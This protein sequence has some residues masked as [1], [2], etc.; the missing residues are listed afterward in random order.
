[1]YST[2]FSSK[3]SLDAE[4]ACHLKSVCP[5]EGIAADWAGVA[6]ESSRD[7]ANK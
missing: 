5:G 1:M 3:P 4:P 7:Q 6:G 2:F